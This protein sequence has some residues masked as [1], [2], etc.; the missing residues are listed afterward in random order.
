MME[1]AADMASRIS[2]VVPTMNE[3]TD[4]L[5]VLSALT[6][7]RLRGHEIVVVDGGSVDGTPSLAAP[8]ADRVIASAAGRASQMNAGAAAARGDV[9]WFLHA[10]TVPAADADRTLL[11]ALAKPGCD[12]GRF[13]VR[14]SGCARML[15]IVETLMNL[16]S[17]L[18][19]IATGDQGIFV[20]RALFETVGGFPELPLME[21]I[22]LSR[23]L[24]CHGRPAC[25]RTKLIVSSR[26][27]EQNGTLRTIALMWWLRLA[28]YCG[29]DPQRLATWYCS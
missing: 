6:G 8:L 1:A 12:W 3:A 22:A 13:N 14:L 27:W 11:A 4:I 24:K 2:V 19:G 17:C 5:T 21:D 7:L 23:Q 20:R 26:R 28:Y 25:V 16:R 10:D 18:T 15:R 9:L 29:F